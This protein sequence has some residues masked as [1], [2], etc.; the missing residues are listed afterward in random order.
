MSYLT[1][2]ENAALSHSGVPRP[3]PRAS[4][5]LAAALD[6][7]PE[8][9][10]AFAGRDKVVAAFRAL[11]NT[12]HEAQIADLTRAHSAQIVDAMVHNQPLPAPIG[13]QVTELRDRAAVA[14]IEHEALRNA[15]ASLLDH[16]AHIYRA[17]PDTVA[18]H[19]HTRLGQI[20]DQ[21]RDLGI[22]PADIPTGNDAL[23]LGEEQRAALLR[24]EEL[25]ADLAELRRSQAEALSR[26]EL[27]SAHYFANTDELQPWGEDAPWPGDPGRPT[28]AHLAWVATTPGARTW[29]PTSDQY[30]DAHQRLKKAHQRAEYNHLKAAR[31][32]KGAPLS[33][34]QEHRLGQLE[35]A[36]KNTPPEDM[37]PSENYRPHPEVAAAKRRI[38]ARNRAENHRPIWR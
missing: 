29:V 36:V 15:A 2:L 24:L 21:A 37:S 7:I 22:T 31:R 20:I 6:T 38:D 30:A 26:T 32:H 11:P 13:E 5:P 17:S 27:T 1:A 12:N 19:L 8:W 4:R 35:R 28:A 9:K 14:G 10:A 23:R 16:L 18:A 34:A 3:T 25:T 33:A